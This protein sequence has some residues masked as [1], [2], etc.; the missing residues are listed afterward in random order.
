MYK[1]GRPAQY[2]E[3]YSIPVIQKKNLKKSGK[4]LNHLVHLN[5][6][7]HCKYTLIFKKWFK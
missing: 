3:L 5:L 7:Q 4:E 2:R 6:T 1:K